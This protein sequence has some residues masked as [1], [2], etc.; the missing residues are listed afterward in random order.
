MARATLGGRDAGQHLA[1]VLAAACP[2]RLAAFAAGDCS[3]HGG[4]PYG[5]GVSH[6]EWLVARASAGRARQALAAQGFGVLTEIDVTAT[7]QAKLG[8][9]IEDYVILGACNPASALAELSSGTASDDG[10]A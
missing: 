5:L 6:V 10:R 9:Q 8:E 3:A 2:V 4:S 1:D 7:L